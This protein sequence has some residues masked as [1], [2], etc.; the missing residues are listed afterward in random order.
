M[1]MSLIAAI[2][3][4][5]TH[6]SSHQ[7]VSEQSASRLSPVL[8]SPCLYNLFNFMTG[9]MPS[10]NPEGIIF[11]KIFLPTLT[12]LSDFKF[13][14]QSHSSFSLSLYGSFQKS[15]TRKKEKSKTVNVHKVSKQQQ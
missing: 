8:F 3:S 5:C 1:L 13:K 11:Y 14:Q 15:S 4:Q 12:S 9:C 10:S 7:R 2:I 6:A